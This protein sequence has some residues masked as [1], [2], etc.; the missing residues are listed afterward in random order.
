M[1]PSSETFEEFFP[2]I[3]ADQA[4]RHHLGPHGSRNLDQHSAA[5]FLSGLVLLTRKAEMVAA[6]TQAFLQDVAAI[7]LQNIEPG[8]AGLERDPAGL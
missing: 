7:E 2:G 1:W 5:Q 3:S 8:T 6:A 4:R